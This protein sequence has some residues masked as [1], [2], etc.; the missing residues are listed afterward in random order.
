VFE[1]RYQGE[2]VGWATVGHQG[3]VLECANEELDAPVVHRLRGIVEW[4]VQDAAFAA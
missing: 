3:C 2:V 1:L 4:L